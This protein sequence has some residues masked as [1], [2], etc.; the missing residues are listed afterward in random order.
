M[1]DGATTQTI[2]L[3]YKYVGRVV[4]DLKI[5]IYE[6]GDEENRAEFIRSNVSVNFISCRAIYVYLK[7]IHICIKNEISVLSTGY[8]S[9]IWR[10]LST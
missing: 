5:K 8:R 9:K 6:L 3:Q 1:P 4:H 10:V 7:F 2:I